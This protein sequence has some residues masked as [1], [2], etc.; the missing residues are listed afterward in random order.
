MKNQK[1]ISR[2][3]LVIIFFIFFIIIVGGI[4]RLTQSG[5]SIVEWNVVVGISPPLN[6]LE[7]NS[8]F[9]KYKQSPE[10]IINNSAINISDFKM[11]YFWEYLHR[12]LARIL[13]FIALFP[14]IY[15]IFTKKINPDQRSRFL[16][17]PLLIG[18]QGLIGWLMVKSGLS[19]KTYNG[20]GVSHYWLSLHLFLALST[21][22]VVLWNYL[23]INN[24]SLQYADCKE[25]KY[26]ITIFIML[27]I[28]IIFGAL[29]AGLD[30]GSV[31]NRF[32]DIN[33]EFYPSNAFF[34]LSNPYFVHFIHRWLPFIIAFIA[35]FMF[36]KIKENLSTVQKS[37]FG[38]FL[39]LFVIQIILG[40]LTVLT[41]VNIMMAI[42]HQINAV[43]M[44]TISLIILF[45]LSSKQ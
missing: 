45:S 6:D 9:D 26:G 40:I 33:G 2:W 30:G 7:W 19:M 37:L 21:Y 20:I 29:L 12:L 27:F 34:D 31:T 5:L 44:L 18:I 4:T 11:I 36:Y 14:L 43:F 13:G 42:M 38:M 23:K 16:I 25:L 15:F 28:Q 1:D 24:S 22:C 41:S 35:V 17:I 32:P 10:Y 8:E 3:L 39:G